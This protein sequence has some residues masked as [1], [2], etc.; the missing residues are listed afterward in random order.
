V[1][2][3]AQSR[4]QEF[5]WLITDTVSITKTPDATKSGKNM[6]LQ[7]AIAAKA[8]PNAK[9]PVSPMKTFALYLLCI[10]NPQHAPAIDAPNTPSSAETQQFV[11]KPII[12]R[13]TW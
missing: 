9:D 3:A 5:T 4:D 6:P 13:I 10:R 11:H 1:K 12:A 8:P 2:A 7:D